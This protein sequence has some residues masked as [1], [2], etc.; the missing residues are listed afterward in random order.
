M[1]LKRIGP[2][3]IG[4]TL[5]KGSFSKVKL[6]THVETNENVAIKIISK[7]GSELDRDQLSLIR[8]EITIQ[9][10]LKHPNVLEIFQVYEQQDKLFLILEYV[11]HGELFDYIIKCGKVPTNQT[12]KFFQQII[13]GLEHLH[14]FSISHRDLKPENL[15]LDEN[16][17]IKISDFGMAKITKSGKLLKTACGSPH[18]VSP[19]IINGRKYDGKKSDIW[20]C[21]VILYALLCGSLPFDQED[22]SQ[23]LFHIKKGRYLLPTHLNELEK[24]LISRM[25]N[26]HP[27]ERISIRDIK[28]HPW[29]TFNFPIRYI[30]PS[31]P[32]DY[33]KEIMGPMHFT[34]FNEKIVEELEQLGFMKKEQINQE[35]ESQTENLMKIFYKIYEKNYNKNLMKNENNLDSTSNV[36]SK[37]KRR[38]LPINKRINSLNREKQNLKNQKKK[39]KSKKHSKT[40][41]SETIL[42][43]QDLIKKTETINDLG[44]KEFSKII[45]KSKQLMKNNEKNNNLNL[46]KNKRNNNNTNKKMEND[47]KAIYNCNDDQNNGNIISSSEFYQ[48]EINISNNEKKENAKK[49]EKKTKKKKKKKKKKEIHIK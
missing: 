6:A 8:R 29:F 19:E 40:I 45:Y 22:Y 21:G 30:P 13:Y 7:A 36:P 5:G 2:Y 46:Q 10:L 41:K 38:S 4:K 14:S 20:S 43:L 26:I 34:K 18:Y 15:L 1:S 16:N 37:K 12:R 27:D 9:K 49:Q 44:I 11:S 31:P 28:R 23:L 33:G 25:L 32:V 48:N 39:K 17:N 47:Q 35:L 3:E 42:H 24:D